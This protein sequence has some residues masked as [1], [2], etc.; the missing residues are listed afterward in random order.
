VTYDDTRYEIEAVSVPRQI[1]ISGIAD[2]GTL[3]QGGRAEA[4][5]IFDYFR[6]RARGP[7][8]VGV[9]GLL[10]SREQTLE[11]DLKTLA[12]R[13]GVQPGRV[14]VV[15]LPGDKASVSFT[16]QDYEVSLPVCDFERSTLFDPYNRLTPRAGCAL[17]RSIG[18]M[19]ARPADLVAP[20]PSSSR[21]SER[22]QTVT[23]LYETGEA[24]GSK[25][26]EI[27]EQAQTTN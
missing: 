26:E 14:E 1:A 21:D 18:A 27:A 22:V 6:N 4:A 25:S 5:H 24:T 10:P 11:T 19:I 2:D 15:S 13:R 9:T 17:N 16:F 3:T 20:P 8:I 23:E 7:L 12:L